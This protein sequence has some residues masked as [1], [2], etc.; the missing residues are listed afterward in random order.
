M[1]RARVHRNTIQGKKPLA[2]CNAHVNG[3]VGAQTD[4]DCRARAGCAGR[5]IRPS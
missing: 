5:G 2:G 3:T 1:Q 4:T